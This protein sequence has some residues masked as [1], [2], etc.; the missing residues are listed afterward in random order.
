MLN[1]A[2][3]GGSSVSSTTLPMLT[4]GREEPEVAATGSGVVEAAGAFVSEVEVMQHIL[5]AATDT[6]TR[7]SLRRLQELATRAAWKSGA[8][9]GR[10]KKEVPLCLSSCCLAGRRVR[11]GGFGK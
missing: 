7:G 10:T 2:S 6:M 4:L 8:S 9:C 11:G 3:R 5:V 1:S